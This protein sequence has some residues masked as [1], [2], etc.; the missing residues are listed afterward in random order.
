VS[1]SGLV[2]QSYDVARRLCVAGA[3]SHSAVH[4]V[5]GSD[6]RVRGLSAWARQNPGCIEACRAQVHRV[7]GT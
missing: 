1:A 7:L 4:A 3:Q 6:M 2:L 5:P